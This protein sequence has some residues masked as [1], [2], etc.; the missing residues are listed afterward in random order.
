MACQ[1][2]FTDRYL[3]YFDLLFLASAL[4]T[5]IFFPQWCHSNF[6]TQAKKWLI[7]HL[8]SGAIPGEVSSASQQTP[9]QPM[10]TNFSQ[11]WGSYSH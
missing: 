10:P 8:W 3:V 6:Q 2:F 9:T 7:P 5:I 11:S 4:S 1:G